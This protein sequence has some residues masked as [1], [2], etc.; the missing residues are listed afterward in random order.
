METLLAVAGRVGAVLKARGDT[1]A[2]SE[3]S[4]GGLVSAALLSVPGAS[5][6]FMG[7][8]VVYTA[9][10]RSSLLAIGEAEMAGLRSSSEPYAMLLARTLRTRF[11]V[12]WG[13][14]E[15]GAAGPAGNRY[16]DPAGLTCLAVSGPVENVLTLR[17]GHD[18]RVANMRA[19]GAGLL[20]AF[21]QVL[22]SMK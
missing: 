16:G 12:T 14:A 6:Y 17:T 9:V 10:A 18:D 19:F 8:A 20:E 3:S 1:V 22:T 5:R 15:T 21:E 13:I 4:A 7:G 2:V 11:G